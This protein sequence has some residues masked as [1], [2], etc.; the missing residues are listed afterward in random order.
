MTFRDHFSHRAEDYAR[1]RPTY[2][3]ALYERLAALAPSTRWACDCATGSGQAAVGLAAHFERV[4]AADASPQ[5]LAHATAHARVDYV[6]GQAERLP[7]RTSSL[8]LV[9]AAAAAHWFELPAF[10]AEVRRV[11]RPGGVVAL[12]SYYM[13]ESEAAIDACMDRLA[14]E[15]LGTYWPGRIVHNRRR[16][17]DLDFPF[18]RLDMP[19]FHAHAVWPLEGLFGYVRSWSAW[20]RYHAAHGADPTQLVRADLVRAWGDPERRVQLRWLLHLLVGRV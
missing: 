19:P 15:I 5:Q 1:Y 9:T 3:A 7:V 13:F 4:L 11:L 16:Y 2:P 17:A 8:D 20:Q 10:H 18:A 6:R 14:H 12:W